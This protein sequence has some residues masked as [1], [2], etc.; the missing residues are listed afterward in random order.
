VVSS[1]EE[2]EE[3]EEDMP[4][5]AMV[6]YPGDAEDT[7]SMGLQSHALLAPFHFIPLARAAHAFGVDYGRPVPDN[8]LLSDLTEEAKDKLLMGAQEVRWTGEPFVCAGLFK[9]FVHETLQ[10]V[11]TRMAPAA[12]APPAPAPPAPASP[13]MAAA[14]AAARAAAAARP[15]SGGCTPNLEMARSFAEAMQSQV[16]V[17]PSCVY[18]IHKDAPTASASNIKS[19][20]ALYSKGGYMG[21]PRETAVVCGLCFKTLS[22]SYAKEGSS[23]RHRFCWKAQ[24]ASYPA[25]CAGIV[26]EE[27]YLYLCSHFDNILEESKDLQAKD[28]QRL[29]ASAPASPTAAGRA[30]AERAGAGGVR[31]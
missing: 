29:A 8:V 31:L 21:T 27:M 6:G 1:D 9:T 19:S 15:P 23:R 24:Y 18:Q 30:Q 12:P 16:P 20:L 14:T 17:D 2:A 7:S 26:P 10:D 4:A 13:A 5:L 11:A 3:E 25:G 28:A 22:L